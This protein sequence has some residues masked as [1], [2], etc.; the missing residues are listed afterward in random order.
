MACSDPTARDFDHDADG[1]ASDGGDPVVR[2]AANPHVTLLVVR[3][4]SSYLTVRYAT[5]AYDETTAL[6]RSALDALSAAGRL[7]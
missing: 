1:Y 6:A 5:G 7:S 2:S 3:S 4:G